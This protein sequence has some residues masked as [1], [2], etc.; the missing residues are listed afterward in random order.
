MTKDL[1]ARIRLLSDGVLYERASAFVND[2]GTFA[3][4]DQGRKQV[5]GLQKYA[6]EGI[7]E[8]VKYAVKQGSRDWAGSK[9]HY[10]AI[11]QSLTNELKGGLQELV[12]NEGL[13]PEGLVDKQKKA[14]TAEITSRLSQE[15]IQHLVAEMLYRKGGS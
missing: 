9:S 1:E 10:K 5:K 11:Y 13:V 14:Q 4:D 12:T 7:G 15:F 2:Q 3:G 8:L 6:R